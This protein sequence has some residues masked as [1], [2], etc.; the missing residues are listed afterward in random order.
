MRRN[1]GKGAMPLAALALVACLA[2][3]DSR[4]QSDCTI[5][6]PTRVAANQPFTLCVS[7]RSRGMSYAWSGPG[8]NAR[9]ACIDVPGQPPGDYQYQLSAW[10]NG[11]EQERCIHTVHV[12][13]WQ[14]RY[15]NEQ[16]RWQDRGGWQNGGNEATTSDNP[17]GIEGP[18]WIGRGQTARL[19]A[20]MMGGQTYR[21]TAPNGQTAM[22]RCIRVSMPGTYYLTT[23][24]PNTGAIRR[25]TYVVRERGG[26]GE[27]PES[28]MTVNCP[29]EMNWWREQMPN[30]FGSLARRDVPLATLREIARRVDQRSRYFNWNDDLTG[31]RTALSPMRPM[32]Y[33]KN[34]AREFATL[35]ANVAAGD[36]N[37]SGAVRPVANAP[38]SDVGIEAN[39]RISYRGA[40]TIQDLIF[41]IDNMLLSRTGDFDAAARYL[42]DVNRGVGIGPTC[43]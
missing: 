24:D 36:M 33:R 38:T 32:T 7:D 8:V 19:C 35:L 2:G 15:G 43:D 27:D 39:T 30:T 25:C 12:G 29:R 37:L 26:W 17:C 5:D 10:M 1:T 22:S 9:S 6:G 21:W 14:D 40:R 42:Q 4:A 23:R 20:G 18:Q 34:L 41:R 31:L 3:T 11:V 16:D 13:T 28:E